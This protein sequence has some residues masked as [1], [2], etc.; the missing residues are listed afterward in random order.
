MKMNGFNRREFLKSALIGAAFVL[1]PGWLSRPLGFAKGGAH[2]ANTHS[3]AA[4][5]LV[6]RVRSS[7]IKKDGFEPGR[8]LDFID[9]ERLDRMVGAGIRALAGTDDQADAWRRVMTGYK[10]GQRIAIK[11]NFNF[12]EDGYEHTVTAPELIGA[13]TGAILKHLGA[14]PEDIYVYDLCKIIPEDARKRIGYPVNYVERI[15]TDT[16]AGKIRLRAEYGLATPD[17]DSPIRMRE[18]IVDEKGRPVECYA[19]KILAS[20]EHLI[21]MPLLTNHIFVATSGALKNH[22]GTVRF[23]NLRQYP[24]ALHGEVMEKS[25]ADINRSSRIAGIT[26]LIIAD[27]LFGVYDRGEGKG[28]RP[29]KTLGGFPESIFLSKDPVAVDSVMASFVMRERTHNKMGNNPHEYLKEAGDSG[30]G[31][32]ELATAPDKFTKIDYREL[33]LPS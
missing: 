14:S 2:A 31:V 4:G 16:I 10:K 27:G 21:N 13:V 17:R 26:R 1:L 12:I 30:L 18:H 19:P 7:V 29:W 6:L 5:P 3:G 20:V 32:F 11:P 25:I 23:G 33:R 8:Y 9:R 28:K 22:Y 15:D 24:V